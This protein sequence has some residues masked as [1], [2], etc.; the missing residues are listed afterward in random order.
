MHA[1]YQL[2]PGAEARLGGNGPTPGRA[3]T[4]R[5]SAANAGEGAG[6]VVAGG[7]PTRL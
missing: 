4:S 1:A 3:A 5:S 6:P 7:G 2:P